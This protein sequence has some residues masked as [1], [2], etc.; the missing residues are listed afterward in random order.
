MTQNSKKDEI[1]HFRSQATE[2]EFQRLK[3]KIGKGE[4]VISIG[5]DK[6]RKLMQTTQ[7]GYYY[8]FF[9]FAVA[10]A[11][12]TVYSVGY[13]NRWYTAVAFA[14]TLMVFIFFWRSMTRR[15]SAWAMKEK[16]N[17]D[18]AYYTN[19]ITISKDEEEYEHPDAHWKDVL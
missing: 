8:S 15:M 18:Y 4:I 11:V 1:Y 6:S 2:N 17:F 13:G 7:A 9:A 14:T 16:N 19:V 3:D 12:L 10:L 5:R